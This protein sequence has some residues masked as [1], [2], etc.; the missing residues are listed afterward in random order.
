M[1]VKIFSKEKIREFFRRGIKLKLER[2]IPHIKNAFSI[3]LEKIYEELDADPE[4]G[5]NI[6]KIDTFHQN[7][8]MN[9]I[10]KAGISKLKI[11]LAPIFNIFIVILMISACIMVFLG[12][13]GSAAISFGIIIINAI[14]AIVQQFRAQKTIESLKK[15]SA[16][17]SNTIREGKE[18]EISSLELI[19]G[20]ILVLKQGDK[21]PADAR[22][23]ETVDLTVDEAILTGESIPVEKN[24]EIISIEDDDLEN[25]IPLQHQTN[26]LFMGTYL[27]TGRSKAIVTATG[28][29]TEIGKISKNLAQIEM[30]DIPL[31]KKMNRFAKF[32]A[33][34]VI[35]LLGVVFFYSLLT[36]PAIN[37]ELIRD[38]F[39]FALS[40]G[41]NVVPINLPL[42]TTIILITGV[43]NL[44]KGGV[45]IRNLSAVESL[46]RVSVILSDKT[47]TITQNQ[48]TV[49]KFWYNDKV[50]D[51]EG[52][53]YDK[54]G[55]ILLN[56]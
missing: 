23:M 54:V 13:M 30:A 8:G 47:G 38:K 9:D 51:V 27:T 7:Y 41:M 20:D 35:L 56:G 32:L 36:A 43:L 44:A 14:T 19:P 15:I 31:T 11:Y 55:K 46:G 49:K 18:Q 3:P 6:E 12:E 21:V 37:L 29:N 42:L 28:V 1:P 53:G 17:T 25:G 5:V 4:K 34:V 22:I 26:M 33:L 10:P 40:I 50:Y 2:E 45:I 16:L 39:K 48:M 52:S 24:S